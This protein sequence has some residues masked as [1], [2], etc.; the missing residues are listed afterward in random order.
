[1]VA[2][3][4]VDYSYLAGELKKNS[5]ESR[6]FMGLKMLCETVE[7]GNA[8]LLADE[9]LQC[10]G[11]LEEL[12]RT[13]DDTVGEERKKKRVISR[14]FMPTE[15]I[16][17][18]RKVPNYNE[19]GIKTQLSP[20][21][22]FAISKEG[23]DG[24]NWQIGRRSCFS[25]EKYYEDWECE[26]KRIQLA[27]RRTYGI[28]YSV[29]GE[30]EDAINRFGCSDTSFKIFDRYA[31]GL[32]EGLEDSESEKLRESCRNILYWIKMLSNGFRNN[33]R[34]EI[35]ANCREGILEHK[36]EKLCNDLNRHLIEL[37]SA[38]F[39]A[40]GNLGQ[41]LVFHLIP[42]DGR[43]LCAPQFHDRFV[44]SRTRVLSIGKGL[45]ALNENGRPTCINLQYCGRYHSDILMDRLSRMVH[46]VLPI[47][48]I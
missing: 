8:R 3:Y 28:S 32:G 43:A 24:A 9:Q 23:Y 46:D 40:E 7:F 17:W 36:I 25:L 6:F 5:T 39:G 14:F 15:T 19:I 21:P 38:H 47:I 13:F 34:F 33:C 35:W 26:K 30:F 42:G 10:L 27:K 18:F 11:P 31:I 22:M 41:T 20:L 29:P 37:R 45:D 2:D 16:H 12:Y 4:L 48:Q 44:C 1:M